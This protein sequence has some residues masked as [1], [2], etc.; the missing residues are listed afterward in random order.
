MQEYKISRE[1]MEAWCKVPVSQLEGHPDSKVKI[2]MRDTRREIAELIG[3]L[4]AE[5]LIAN[6]KVGKVTRWV[7]PS[8]PEDQYKTFI[9]RVNEERINL[10]NLWVFHMDEILDWQCRPY[11][12]E[13]RPESCKGRMLAR[14]YGKIDPELNVPERQR[15]WPM[16]ADMDYPDQM[17][18]KLGGIDTVW[19]GLGYKGL[20]A[21]NESPQDPYFRISLQEYAQSKTRIIK[22]NVDSIIMKSERNFGGMYD[23]CD[24]FMLTLGFQVLLSARRAVFMV[25]TGKWKSTAIRVMMFSE[26]TL[27][28]PATLMPAYIPEVVI[29]CDSV[30]A[31]HPLEGKEIIL[32]NENYGSGENE[33]F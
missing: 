3:N 9:R 11:P 21:A 30:T 28:Y 32:S 33:R 15:I 26:P 19:G 23:R 27:E 14:F 5:E 13:N 2:I 29:A 6:N 16:I 1:E 8:G 4:M 25:T 22:K 24:P 20:V 17:C 12:V 7:L 31:K 10:K 18:R